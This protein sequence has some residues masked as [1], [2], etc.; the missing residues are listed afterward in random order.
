MQ[1]VCTS[2]HLFGRVSW[3]KLPEYVFETFETAPIKQGQ[4]QKFIL[5]FTRVIYPKNCS[6][7]TCHY[8]LITPNQQTLCIETSIF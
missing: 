4:F 5:N 1:G 2:N 8:W 7:Q 6:N 3:D